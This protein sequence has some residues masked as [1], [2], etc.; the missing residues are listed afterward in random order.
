MTYRVFKSNGT[1]CIRK[2]ENIE[3]AKAWCWTV[4]TGCLYRIEWQY[5][6]ESNPRRLF[7]DNI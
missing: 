5:E 3:D 1:K 4:G 2:F 6:N 7:I